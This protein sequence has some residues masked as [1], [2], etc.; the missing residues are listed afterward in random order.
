MILSRIESLFLP[1]SWL[2]FATSTTYVFMMI[3]RRK[4]CDVSLRSLAWKVKKNWMIVQNHRERLG[5][6]IESEIIIKD[7]IERE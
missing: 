1:S 5:E 3:D 2:S 4:R 7:D 6:W